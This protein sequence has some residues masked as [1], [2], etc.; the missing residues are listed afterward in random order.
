MTVYVVHYWLD[1]VRRTPGHCLTDHR[2]EKGEPIYVGA[3]RAT[4]RSCAG[5]TPVA[6]ARTANY[7]DRRTT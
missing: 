1:D 3:G 5:G 7:G 6:K 4:V 2:V